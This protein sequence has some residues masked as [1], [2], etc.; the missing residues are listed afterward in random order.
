MTE[1]IND[2]PEARLV[3]IEG[4]VQGVGFRAYAIQHARQLRLKGWVRNRADGTVEA[5]V[6]GNV[7][8]IEAFVQTCIK[9]PPG[10]RVT[11]IELDNAEP[12]DEDGF[13]G[14]PTL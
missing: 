3:R 7:K 13:V 1:E 8:A 14:R 9:G 11:A 6:S 4:T 5:L 12:P 2:A 10:A